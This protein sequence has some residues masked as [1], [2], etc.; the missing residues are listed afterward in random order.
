MLPTS[1]NEYCPYCSLETRVISYNKTR[2]HGIFLAKPPY[3]RS[4]TL[5]SQALGIGK[6]G[7]NR[8]VLSIETQ[9]KSGGA[10]GRHDCYYSYPCVHKLPIHGRGHRVH[11]R[12]FAENLRMACVQRE[13]TRPGQIWC[14]VAEVCALARCA[15]SLQQNIALRYK[16]LY[17]DL[18][19]LIQKHMTFNRN[20][21]RPELATT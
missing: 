9:A 11:P 17:G 6:V 13:K 18:L 3:R 14:C 20:S 7:P 2:P 12:H 19:F 21:V 8:S 1:W 5:P 15:Q 16:I 4:S 10:N